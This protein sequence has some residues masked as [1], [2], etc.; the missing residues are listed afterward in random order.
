[1]L[2]WQLRI[3]TRAWHLD[4]R[5]LDVFTVG[6][7]RKKNASV[8]LRVEVLGRVLFNLDFIL[9]IV[10]W[11]GVLPRWQVIL[12]VVRVFKHFPLGSNF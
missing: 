12:D 8:S 3:V 6:H 5:S 4:F 9:V 7:P 10:A 2:W 11:T 1:M